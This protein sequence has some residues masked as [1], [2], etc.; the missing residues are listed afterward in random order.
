MCFDTPTLNVESNPTHSLEEFFFCDLGY[1]L[2]TRTVNKKVSEEGGEKGEE[3]RGEE[4]GRE[5]G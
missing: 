1:K 3:R 4:G 2:K 5:V